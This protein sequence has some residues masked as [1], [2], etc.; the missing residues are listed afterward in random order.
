M[1]DSDFNRLNIRMSDG[2]E[3]WLFHNFVKLFQLLVTIL[4]LIL[5]I[6]LQAFRII[7]SLT[8]KCCYCSG[9]TILKKILVLVIHIMIGA[10]ASL[11]H[12]ISFLQCT[13]QR[14]ETAP[15]P[16]ICNSNKKTPI[17]TVMFQTNQ[18]REIASEF[19][20]ELWGGIES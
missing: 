16:F 14:V 15:K 11:S 9:S 13:F 2:S 10:T 7:K 20:F 5:F 4:I 6:S 1:Q 3:A 19:A 8:V 17:P 18:N 12:C